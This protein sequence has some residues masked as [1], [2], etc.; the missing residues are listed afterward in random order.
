VLGPLIGQG[1]KVYLDDILVHFIT[2]DGN[3]E[4]L[5]RVLSLHQA[6]KLVAKLSKCVFLHLSVRFL[7]EV[8]FSNG[9]AVDPKRFF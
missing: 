5:G 3:L 4:L 7:E 8:V 1:V 9:V 2:H 6:N